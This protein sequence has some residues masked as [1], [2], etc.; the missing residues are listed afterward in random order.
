VLAGADCIDGDVRVPVVRRAD[1]YGVDVFVGEQ[2]VVVGVA[3]DAVVRLA[4]FCGV[5]F[6]DE[7]FAIFHTI[8]VEI[9]NSNDACVIDGKDIGHVVAARDAAA[10]NGSNVDL[11][12]GRI[13]AEQARGN[14]G[15]EAGDGGGGNS[16]FEERAA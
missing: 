6:I 13:L 4:E 8:R 1:K 14:E 12:A 11:F 15:G 5:G 16:S 9:A 2:I 10:P 3:S 7:L